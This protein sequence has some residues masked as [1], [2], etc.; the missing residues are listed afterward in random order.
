MDFEFTEAQ[1]LMQKNTRNFMDKEII[2]IVEDYER[3]Y[4]PFP[5]DVAIGLMKKLAPFGYTS[6]LIPEEWG[7][8]GLDTIS[9]GI[10][11]EEVCRAWGSLGIMAV[12]SHQINLEMYKCGNN[13]QRKKYLPRLISGDLI[14]SA[15]ITEPDAGSSQ[16]EIQTTI[17]DAGEYY[18]VNGTKNWLT[19]GG[20]SDMCIVLGY[21]D[22]S[23]GYKG[24]CRVIVERPESPYEVRELPKIGLRSCPTA[25]ATFVDCR[26]PKENLFGAEAGGYEDTQMIFNITRV[27]MGIGSCGL[28][29]A[30]ID[31]AV[32]YALE[33]RQFGRPIAQFQLVQNMLA[34]M[35]IETEAIRLLSFKALDL[36]GKRQKC[37]KECSGVKFWGTEMAVR[38]CSRAM[39]ILGSYGISEE[40]RLERYFRD[41]RTLLSP[42]GTSQ[43]QRLIVGREIL[44][45][46]AFV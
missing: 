36:M 24:M 5:Q 18:I 37:S 21:F 33:R 30:A 20:I 2:P 29:Q 44:G 39:E 14:P 7:G 3:R 45:L 28:A 13:E 22:K 9:Y 15:G 10:L 19:H 42:D 16:R 11:V 12:V 1:K 8:A 25:E 38:V 40:Y 35:V 4:R 41:A 34:E 23:K 6:A 26:V 31:E 46:P 43:I 17:T 27:S 32:K